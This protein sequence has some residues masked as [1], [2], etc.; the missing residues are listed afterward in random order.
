MPATR[1]ELIARATMLLPPR[2]SESQIPARPDDME[3]SLLRQLR[4][5]ALR[6]MD[7]DE[8]RRQLTK[9]TTFSLSSTS[10]AALSTS[11]LVDLLPEAYSQAKLY[12]A[13]IAEPASYHRDY[14]TFATGTPRTGLP[15][16]FVGESKLFVRASAPALSASKVVTVRD[17]I[18]VPTVSE[19]N[20]STNTLPTTLEDDL[21]SML[22][23]AQL[24]KIQSGVQGVQGGAS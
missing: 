17:A 14:Y 22:V 2:R 11:G 12:V 24:A 15:R 1:S 6:A 18:F 7:D 8:I 3:E 9:T 21:V 13:G 4:E 20:P 16:W 10:D 19:T 5:L 23:A